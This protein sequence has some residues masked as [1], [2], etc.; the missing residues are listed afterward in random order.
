MAFV[1]VREEILLDAFKNTT[2]G[3]EL[4]NISLRCH[5]KQREDEN[6]FIQTLTQ[7]MK[8]SS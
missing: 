6:C 8:V 7:S 1:C 4:F 5:K 3:E 2:D